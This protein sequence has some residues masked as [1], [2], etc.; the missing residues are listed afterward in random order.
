[1]PSITRQALVRLGAWPL[2][3]HGRAAWSD[4]TTSLSS[5]VRRAVVRSAQIAD[6]A[7]SVW[8][9]VAGEVVP[10]WQ[11]PRRLASTTEPPA[12]LDED[13]AAALLTLPLDVG[14][15]CARVP[16]S[17][18]EARLPAAR[19]EA[20]LL[21]SGGGAA[22]SSPLSNEQLDGG[23]AAR[24]AF[25]RELATAAQ[26]GE[27]LYEAALF[28]FEAYARW[29]LLQDLLGGRELLPAE[30]RRL[31]RRFSERLGDALLGGPLRDAAL[32]AAPPAGGSAGSSAGGRRD[33]LL[34][35]G[36]A[37]CG[38]LLELMRS[39]GLFSRAE[40]QRTLGSGSDFFDESDWQAGG[41][42]SWQYIVSG[43]AV[44]GGSQLAQ[45]RTAATGVGVGF[46]PGQY[47]TAPLARHLEGLGIGA[48]I[49]EYF[50]DNRVGR[51]DPRTFSD[52]RYYSDTLLEVVA[53]P[54]ES[55]ERLPSTTLPWKC[56]GSWSGISRAAT[57]VVRWRAS[58]GGHFVSGLTLPCTMPL[59]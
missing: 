53:L 19:A 9:Q 12:Y 25:P 16:L 37:G 2:L 4:E 44:V 52:P 17:T 32:P 57:G 21:Y 47:L 58:S 6:Q 22:A 5:F 20:V 33:G 42:T 40:L 30:R 45:D 23:G 10:A 48:R 28:N 36:V 24:R 27:P 31:Q 59:P 49:D 14:A 38:A 55:E 13:F 29:R 51:P 15:Q 11:Q 41:G 35:T 50:L 46:Y 26:R 1:M 18:L 54:E 7:D 3:L 8:Q 34:R 39:K 43:S 56:H